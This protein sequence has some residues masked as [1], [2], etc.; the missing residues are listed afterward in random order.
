MSSSKVLRQGGLLQVR[1]KCTRTVGEKAGAGTH[2]Q[3]SAHNTH[4]RVEVLHH[5]GFLQVRE[6][7]TRTAGGKGGGEAHADSRQHTTK[8]MRSSKVLRQGVLLQVRKSG[9]L[10]WTRTAMHVLVI[11]TRR[12]ADINSSSSRGLGVLDTTDGS[13]SRLCAVVPGWCYCQS[14]QR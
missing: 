2:E 5:R 1:E 3:P 14:N 9:Q 12:L 10:Q 4:E 11:V 7:G 8:H 13:A 6:K